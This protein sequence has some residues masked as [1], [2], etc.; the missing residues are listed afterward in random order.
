MKRTVVITGGTKGLGRELSLAFGRAG[1]FVLAFYAAD[2][3]AAEQL[4]ANF[5]DAKISG[6]VVRHDVTLENPAVWSRPE[7]HEAE[8]LALIH[9][10][11]AAF[12]PA[13]L[14]QFGWTEFEA[15]LSVAVKGGWCCAQALI[16]PLL[17]CRRGTIVNVLTS[18]VEGLPPK[19]FA[20]YATA[21]HALR[22]FTLA[23]ASEYAPRGLRVFSVSPGFMHT[24]LTE[25]WDPR[26][27]E[28]VLSAGA[29]VTDPVRGAARVLELVES[30]A[31]AGRGEEFPI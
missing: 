11:C 14:H 28:A 2:E 20:A 27:R 6:A 25:R 18:A 15:N 10:A 3:A 23:L 4:R 7:I 31:T 24:A 16:R 1:W 12:A 29:R 26:L 30:E 21:K 17:K 13:P 9:N 19:G 22:G 8:H 5:L